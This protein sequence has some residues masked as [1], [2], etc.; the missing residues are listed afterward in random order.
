MDYKT[1]ENIKMRLKELLSECTI[2]TIAHRFK[3]IVEYDRVLVIE[4][5][6]VVEFDTPSN[7][8][9]N[10]KS[11]LFQLSKSNDYDLQKF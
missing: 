2:I 7:L 6:K 4:K 8:I 3:S 9:G 1:E 11:I 10:E 5:G